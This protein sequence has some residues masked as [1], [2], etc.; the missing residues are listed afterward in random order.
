MSHCPW[1]WLVPDYLSYRRL[2]IQSLPPRVK[3]NHL[4]LHTSRN[5]EFITSHSATL[6]MA[7]SLSFQWM[8]TRSPLT[9][10]HRTLHWL[11]SLELSV[12]QCWN[13][14]SGH[15]SPT[16]RSNYNSKRHAWLGNISKK[17]PSPCISKWKTPPCQFG[18]ISCG[19]WWRSSES[20]C[21][22]AEWQSGSPES[23]RHAA[24]GT[25]R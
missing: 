10:N 2:C 11:L 4:D 5:I 14:P 1:I 7:N 22:G 16:K 24:D 17:V 20:C 8:D 25:T 3:K 6:K 15:P 9:Q 21:E 13:H 18:A 19:R 23:D 12:T